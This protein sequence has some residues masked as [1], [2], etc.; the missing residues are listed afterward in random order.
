[1]AA[2]K[3]QRSTENLVPKIAAVNGVLFKIAK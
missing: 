2:A 1:M 3:F